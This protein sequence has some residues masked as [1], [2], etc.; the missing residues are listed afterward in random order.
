VR[1]CSV[2]RHPDRDAL[3]QEFLRW[4]SPEALA[5]DY[6][7]SDHSSIY[8]HAH[9]TGLFARRRASIR[10]ALGS[11]IEQAESVPVTAADVVNAVRVYA[12]INDAGEWIESNAVQP[13]PPASGARLPEPNRQPVRVEH[14][15]TR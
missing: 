8:R 6:G 5:R 1:K 9:A 7:I 10:L 13:R 2:C 3:E 15:P 11:L 12:H 4:R 14:A